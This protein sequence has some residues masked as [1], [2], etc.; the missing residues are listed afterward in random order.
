M[1]KSLVEGTLISENAQNYVLI[2]TLIVSFN[3]KHRRRSGNISR[4][5]RSII[6][7]RRRCLELNM[8]SFVVGCVPKNFYDIPRKCVCLL[9]FISFLEIEIGLSV[10]GGMNSWFLYEFTVFS[11]GSISANI[12]DNLLKLIMP[13]RSWC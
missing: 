11:M 9:I 12:A 1:K 6:F 13:C 8:D 2:P 3:D 7:W 5:L 10:G 4:F